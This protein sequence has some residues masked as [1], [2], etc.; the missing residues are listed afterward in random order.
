[1]RIRCTSMFTCFKR[2]ETSRRSNI[3]CWP[4]R[5]TRVLLPLAAYDSRTI[6]F[7]IKARGLKKKLDERI[8]QSIEFFEENQIEAPHYFNIKRFTLKK[9]TFLLKRDTSK[10]WTKTFNPWIA[11]IMNSN[12]DVQLILDEYS[13]AAYVVDYVNKS[14]PGSGNLYRELTKLSESHPELTQEALVI[15]MSAQEASWF[16]LRQPMSHSSRD[17]IYI[18]TSW[19]CELHKSCKSK[20]QLE[21][22]EQHSTDIWTKNIIQKYEERSQ[23]LESC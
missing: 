19:P 23:E 15:E 1:M 3:P 10:I 13:C 18:P 8:Y 5:E 21:S 9:P 20:E 14:D 2:G 17:L 16:L 12:M 22:L 7:R 4:M 11:S 6:G